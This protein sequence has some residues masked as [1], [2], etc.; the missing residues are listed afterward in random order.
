MSKPPAHLGPAGRA[1]WTR[2]VRALADQDDADRLYE[3]AARYAHAVDLAD[4]ARSEW[5]AAGCP[6]SKA[7]GS[8]VHPLIR[9]MQDADRD[10]ARFGEAVGLK[11]GSVK[12]RGPDPVAMITADIGESPAAALRRVK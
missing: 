8:A 5:R 12:H 3:L 2:A 4:R 7:S 6:F 11:P 1:A 9:V 10:A